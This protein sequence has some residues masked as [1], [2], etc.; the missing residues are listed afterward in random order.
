M[1]QDLWEVLISI[2]CLI[3][4][5]ILKII[6]RTQIQDCHVLLTYFN[7]PPPSKN[8]VKHDG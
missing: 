1:F 3:A 7:P 6:I 5:E 8:N 4:I 2:C